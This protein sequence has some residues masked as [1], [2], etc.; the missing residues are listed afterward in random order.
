MPA[1][2]SDM[3]NFN[4]DL[5]IGDAET[6]PAVATRELNGYMQTFGIWDKELSTA[7]ANELYNSGSAKVAQNSSMAANLVDWWRFDSSSSEQE[8]QTLPPMSPLYKVSQLKDT[9]NQNFIMP[10]QALSTQRQTLE[11]SMSQLLMQT[12]RLD[13]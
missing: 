9:H 3:C 11:R 10:L 6:D 1:N 7:E 5:Y 8:R 2:V 12:V 13:L 4:Q